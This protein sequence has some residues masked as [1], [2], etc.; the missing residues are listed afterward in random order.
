MH[1]FKIDS[2]TMEIALY[3]TDTTALQRLGFPFQNLFGIF[4]FVFV[5]L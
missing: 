2:Q 1:L 4:I 5:K 3:Y